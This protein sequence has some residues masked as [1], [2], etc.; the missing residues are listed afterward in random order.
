MLVCDR[1]SYQNKLGLG[2]QPLDGVGKAIIL[3]LANFILECVI[4]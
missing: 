2:S 1:Y 3:F 4:T